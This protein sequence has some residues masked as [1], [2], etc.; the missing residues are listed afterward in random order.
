M[1]AQN[2]EKVDV[3]HFTSGQQQ[4]LKTAMDNGQLR[5]WVA[6]KYRNGRADPDEII[7]KA[8]P[9]Q[10]PSAPQLTPTQMQAYLPPF[11]KV[12][13]GSGTIKVSSPP[14]TLDQMLAMVQQ[15]N[16][17]SGMKQQKQFGRLNGF[18]PIRVPIVFHLLGYQ[19]KDGNYLPPY[20]WFADSAAQ[21]LVDVVNK[22][23]TGTGVQ[24][25]VQEVRW[26]P[27]KY[28][29]LNRQDLLGWQNCGK[30]CWESLSSRYN[31]QG[32]P[33]NIWVAGSFEGAFKCTPVAILCDLQANGLTTVNPDASSDWKPGYE[34][35]PTQVL[36]INYDRFS[37]DALNRAAAWEGGGVVAAHE[38]GHYFGL[39]HT[40]EGGCNPPDDGATDTPANLDPDNGWPP[41]WL[42]AL[43]QWCKDFRQG[44]SPDP[45]KLLKYKSCPN[46]GGPRV[47]DN[48][49]NLM[50][51]LD[52]VCRMGLTDN[53][54]ARLQWAIM[55][56]RPG[57]LAKYKTA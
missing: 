32:G 4:Q 18:K 53:Q 43:T 54:V 40:F 29:Y 51:Y 52:D 45:S 11:P 22:F 33:I 30:D 46:A 12:A 42:V 17:K 8:K 44:K 50:S 15:F 35:L 24:F 57:M 16:P 6:K 1:L 21:H 28:S 37:P 19:D 27:R 2:G 49:F 3:G 39:L 20:N 25:Y 9:A 10:M 7:R 14:Q 34:Y 55:T 56:Y 13:S 23:Y 47:I 38:I 48:V 41:D 5:D 36:Y 31:V 26:D